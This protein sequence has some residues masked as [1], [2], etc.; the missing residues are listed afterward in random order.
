MPENRAAW[1][2]ATG[3]KLRVGQSE[4]PKPGAGDIVVR[5]YAVAVNPLDFMYCPKAFR[6]AY[7]WLADK[8]QDLRLFT[9]SWPTIVG[10]DIAGEVVEVGDGVQRF[11]KGDRVILHAP[12]RGGFQ[13]YTLT[14]TKATAILPSNI[15]F[16]EGA[17]FPVAFNA[18][19]VG[20]SSNGGLG[21]PLPSLEPEPSHKTIVVW[22]GSSSVGSFATPLATAAGAKVV[23]VASTQNADF[24][25][26][27]GAVEVCDYKSSTVADN[28]VGAV[29][30][31]GGTFAGLVDAISIPDTVK[32]VLA[33]LEALGGGPLSTV[34]PVYQE[35]DVPSNVK[36][37]FV[38]GYSPAT[39][40]LWEN[41][42]T[43]ALQNGKLKCLP[44]PLVV[45]KGLEAIQEGLDRSKKGVSAKKVVIEL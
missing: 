27:C 15:S 13:L 37:S 35:D 26:H 34:L 30:A 7:I 5:N 20:L 40:P 12:N 41:Y 28:V 9:E 24:C 22:G 2:D 38:H 23:A 18:A 25:K 21:L 39:F 43:P 16:Q 29:K 42:V 10:F 8:I 19:L 31:A 11:K 45:G 6:S 44:E 36:P 33:I 1:L 17:V 3:Q 4:L 32:P 14:N